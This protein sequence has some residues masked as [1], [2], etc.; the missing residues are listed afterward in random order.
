MMLPCAQSRA[1][2]LKPHHSS[3]FGSGKKRSQWTSARH[4]TCKA[5]PQRVQAP[6]RPHFIERPLTSGCQE[7]VS[8]SQLL[9]SPA[10]PILGVSDAQFGAGKRSDTLICNSSILHVQQPGVTAPSVLNRQMNHRV[11]H[12]HGCE[13]SRGVQICMN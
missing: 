13:S 8:P 12:K 3:I 11:E 7:E 6:C 5:Q 10:D 2:A 4:S 9:S 1:S